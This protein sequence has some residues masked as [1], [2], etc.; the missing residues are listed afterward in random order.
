MEE[1]TFQQTDKNK[2]KGNDLPSG[3]VWLW[4][5]DQ[6]KG[7]GKGDWCLWNVDLEKD[8]EGDL[9]RKENERVDTIPESRRR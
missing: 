4:N 7:N 6:D 5:M 3:S 8:A 9:D 1:Q 2:N